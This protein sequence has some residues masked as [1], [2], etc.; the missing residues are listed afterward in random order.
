MKEVGFERI[1]EPNLNRG[2][3]VLAGRPVFKKL[4]TVSVLVAGVNEPRAAGSES[5][6]LRG[7]AANLRVANTSAFDLTNVRLDLSLVSVPDRKVTVIHGP[8]RIDHIKAADS[9]LLDA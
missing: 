1:Q 3:Q 6:P 5:L 4:T 7:P 8:R 9:Y 2:F